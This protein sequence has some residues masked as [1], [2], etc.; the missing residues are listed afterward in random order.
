M[1]ITELGALGEFIGAFLLFASLVYVGIQIRQ[2]NLTDRLNAATAFEDQ[3]RST[4]AFFSSSRDIAEVMA[5]GLE[6]MSSLTDTELHLFGPR[7]YALYR[8]A[9]IAHDQHHKN[10]LGKEVLDR[11]MKVLDIYHGSLG[12]QSWFYSHGKLM[13]NEDFFVYAN[14][15]LGQTA[16]ADTTT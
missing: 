9:E 5:R 10:L 2:S 8:H 4:V 12:A 16:N 7:M 15:R 14:N 6:D 1:T 13:L 3:Y 11:T